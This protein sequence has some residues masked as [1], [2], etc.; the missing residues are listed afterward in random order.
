MSNREGLAFNA[1]LLVI[2]AKKNGSGNSERDWTALVLQ[3]PLGQWLIGLVGTI[4]IG[5]GIYQLYKAY[6]VKFRKQLNLSELSRQQQ[7]WLVGISRF[8]VAA[9]GVV[10]TIIGFFVIQAA[11]RSDPN[12]VRGLD[13]ALQ[14][15]AAQ[16]YGQF[17]LAV[18]AFGLIGYGVYL[19]VQARYRR[20]NTENMRFSRINRTISH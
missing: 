12:E 18:V 19:L 10:F 6:K 5:L 2:G 13:G 14:S 11:R 4:I 3:Q 20:F 7:N 9:R 8:G 16:P 15:L 17:L 1:A